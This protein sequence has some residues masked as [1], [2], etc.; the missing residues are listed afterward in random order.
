MARQ[1]MVATIS[2]QHNAQPLASTENGLSQSTTPALPDG[3]STEK[4][5]CEDLKKVFVGIDLEKFF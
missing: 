5:K 4:T 3:E 1:C 2:R